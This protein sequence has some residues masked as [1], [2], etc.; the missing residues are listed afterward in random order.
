M[1]KSASVILSILTIL[2][3]FNS[4]SVYIVNAAS[5]DNF[6]KSYSLGNDPAQNMVNIAYAQIGKTGS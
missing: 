5:K 4:F 6:N 3:I 2:S 1:K